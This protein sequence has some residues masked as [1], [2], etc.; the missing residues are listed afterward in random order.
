[1]AVDPMSGGAEGALPPDEPLN[2]IDPS[3]V[4]AAPDELLADWLPANDDPARPLMTLS[5][6]AADGT[7]DSRGLLLT[8]YGTEGFWFHTDVRSR[9][10]AQLAVRHGVA[11]QFV[12]PERRRQL[13]VRGTA[14]PATSEE[15]AGAYRARSPY[16]QQLAWLNTDAFAQLPLAD[17]VSG[18]TAFAA[19]HPDGFEEPATWVGYLVRPT[20]M[21]FWSGSG[22]TASRRIVYTRASVDEPWTVSLRAG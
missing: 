16:L 8:E 14:E 6:V 1:M 20:R 5:T 18:W 13:V 21:A 10:V 9:K 15:E 4:P 22:S 2:A 12:W 7:P 11:L 17:R 3:E 19:D